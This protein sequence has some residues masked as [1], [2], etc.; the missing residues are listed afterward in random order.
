MEKPRPV[1]LR[2][3]GRDE[4]YTMIAISSDT[5]KIREALVDLIQLYPQDAPYYGVDM[6]PDKSPV[7]SSLDAA[8]LNTIVLEAA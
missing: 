8:A 2:I 3:G 1:V 5:N 6:N 4:R 7:S